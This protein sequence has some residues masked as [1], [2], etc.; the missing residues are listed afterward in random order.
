MT[1]RSET[2]PMRTPIRISE[3]ES[4]ERT[5]ERTYVE[6]Q[7]V[8]LSG[9]FAE[10][11]REASR[12]DEFVSVGDVIA[13]GALWATNERHEVI[14]SGE[15]DLIPSYVRAAVWYRDGGKCE[16][17]HPEFPTAGPMHLDHIHPWS[18]GGPDTTDNL[19]LLCERHN[20]ER[21][22]FV[23]FA[24][25][26][27]PATWWCSNCYVIDEHRWDYLPPWIVDCPLHGS[28][29]SPEKPRCRV[30]RAVGA[31]YL[32][33]DEIPAWHQARPL[34]EL[35]QLTTIAYCAHC[36]RPGMTGYPL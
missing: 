19:R 26:K 5:N 28:N 2:D 3:Q 4:N 22:N 32:R 13:A 25:P 31:A 8:A 23:D 33:G 10:R 6:G 7:D 12:I 35:E 18:A 15:R 29:W 17:C 11:A 21:S 34:L 24:R 36:N 30:A 27:R 16:Q 20:L 9:S 1:S 14:R